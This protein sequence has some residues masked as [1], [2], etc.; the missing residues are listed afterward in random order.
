MDEQV[1]FLEHL[2]GIAVHVD[3]RLRAVDH[4]ATVTQLYGQCN[5]P[6][7]LVCELRQTL[8]KEIGHQPA[9]DLHLLVVVTPQ[10]DRHRP[11]AVRIDQ[12]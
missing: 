11:S 6:A 10:E 5:L 12:R 8:Q 4:P 2:A 1:A 7:D 9:D 3:H